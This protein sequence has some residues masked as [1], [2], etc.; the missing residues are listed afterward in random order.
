ML[1]Q[2]ATICNTDVINSSKGVIKWLMKLQ[3]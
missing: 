1:L 2:D 3:N